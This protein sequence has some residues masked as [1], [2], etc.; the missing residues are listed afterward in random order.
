MGSQ[1]AWE[2]Q[3]YCYQE[4]RKGDVTRVVIEDTFEQAV[5]TAKEYAKY[6]SMTLMGVRE[7]GNV[8]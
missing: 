5:E 2:I 4:I 7:I 6:N 8:I 1:I 3:Y